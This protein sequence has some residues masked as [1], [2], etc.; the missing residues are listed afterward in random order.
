MAYSEK[1]ILKMIDKAKEFEKTLPI[2]TDSDLSKGIYKFTLAPEALAPY[3]KSKSASF[4]LELLYD[5]GAVL[6]SGKL[7]IT[8]NP[9]KV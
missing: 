3:A 7:V 6:S 1:V 9:K 2:D 8:I 4:D 5:R